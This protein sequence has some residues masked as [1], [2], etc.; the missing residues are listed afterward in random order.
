MINYVFYEKKKH[1]DEA[2]T[3]EV[4]QVNATCSIMAMITTPQGK[5]EL[6]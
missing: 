4:C 3:G 2:V 6:T 1:L 5:L